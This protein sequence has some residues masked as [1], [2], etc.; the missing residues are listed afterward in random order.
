VENSQENSLVETSMELPKRVG[1]VILFFVFG[2]F[3]IWSAVAPLDGAAHA[4][5]TVIVKSHS[6]VVQHLEGGIIGDIMVRNGDAVTASQPLIKI[7]DTQ[8]LAQL[9]IANAQLVALKTREARLIAERDKLDQITY[10]L[11]LDLSSSSVRQEMEA[12]DEIFR[13][14]QAA[15]QGSIDVLEQRIEQLQSKLVGLAALQSSKTDLAASYSEELTDVRELLSQGFSDKLKLREL[16]RNVAML[17]GEAAELSANISSTEVQIGEARLQ[18]IQTEREFHNDVV[19][20]LGEAQTGINDNTERVNALQDIVNR[21][22]VRA[23]VAGIV[24]GLQFHSVGG[25]ISP[26]T[27]IVN[28][29]P[30]NEELIIE[31]QVS[32]TDIDRVTLG[33]EATIRFSAF[34]SSVPTIT[35]KLI[36][37]SADHL[38]DEQTGLSFYQSQVEVTEEGLNDLGSLVLL[39]GMPAEVFINTGSRT[40][41]QY[42]FK[43][44]SNALARSFIED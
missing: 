21:T 6:Q 35:G 10:P 29:V 38:V 12:Q 19:T 33:M 20:Q 22:V 42:L 36:N 3:G 2:V 13:S 14:Q 31:A 24:T 1:F 34:G 37:L 9:E 16:E 25:V 17:E 28:I 32:P 15:L 7:D 39:P 11:E 44:F 41:L 5:G 30:Q 27:P 23:P 40:F 26:G 43:P 8:A 4:V 18:I